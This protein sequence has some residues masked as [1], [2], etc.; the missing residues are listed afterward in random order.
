[1]NQ[2]EPLVYYAWSEGQPLPVAPALPLPVQPYVDELYVP[3]LIQPTPSADGARLRIWMVP[4]QAQLH[5]EL[6]NRTAVWTYR[7][8]P[9]T[10]ADPQPPVGPTIEVQQGQRTHVAWVNAL[11]NP[12]GSFARH[13]VVAVRDLPAVVQLADSGTVHAP[14][15]LPGFT[16]GRYDRAAGQVPPWTVVH[17]HGGRTAADADGWPESGCYPGQVQHSVYDNQQP[18]TL[19]WY[20]DHAMAITRLNVYAGLAGLY[21][22]RD[23]QEHALQL[24]RGVEDHELLLLVQDRALTQAGDHP[25]IVA[26]QLL[27]KTGTAGAD[28]IAIDGGPERVDQAPMEFFGPLTLVN[29]LIWPKATVQA[30]V[31]RLRILNG[32][33]ARTFRLRFTDADGNPVAVPL[34]MIGSDGGLLAR[35][36]DLNEG[37]QR[38][39]PGAITL[40]PAERV[41]V[42]VDFGAFA[43]QRIELRNSASSPFDGADADAA[44]PLAAFLAYP[45]VMCFDVGARSDRHQLLPWDQALLPSAMPWSYEAV[46][47][48]EPVER[49]VAL[50]EN[51]QGVLQLVECAPL[52]DGGHQR[53]WDGQSQL[54]ITQL[55]LRQRGEAQHRLY[56]M[57]PGMFSDTVN[58]LARDGDVEIW[59]IINLSPDTH[60]IHIHLIHF[61]LLARDAYAAVERVPEQDT[62]SDSAAGGYAIQFDSTADAIALDPAETGWKDTIRV[63]PSELVVLAMPFRVYAATDTTPEQGS[64]LYRTGRYMY[65]CHILEHEDHEM[66][67]P[68]VVMPPEVID[69]M[70]AVDAAQIAPSA[71]PS[72]GWYMDPDMHGHGD[73]M[74]GM[75]G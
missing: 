31:Y 69:H 46:R 40:A 48:L 71:E 35:P 5:S 14:Q 64:R 4:A 3:P 19:L 75:T 24:P 58:Y 26:N 43:G 37:A 56:R 53:H 41:D 34:Q 73:T 45:Q 57:L 72:S 33:N 16:L 67:R 9:D 61:K 38:R 74:E 68:L 15:N 59:K 8:S 17:L 1:M 42:L 47:R 62:T 51:D 28:P 32:A 54:P 13:P 27:H 66:M 23:P 2:Q 63:N 52:A 7:A 20:H 30:D 6:P 18:G 29:G 12:D 55:A 25:D 65:H 50:V 60:P 49:L 44:D 70:H 22:I 39:Y 11:T 10:P 21:I 36:V